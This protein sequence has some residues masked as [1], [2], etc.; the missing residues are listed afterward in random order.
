VSRDGQS[1]HPIAIYA[2]GALD[3]AADGRSEELGFIESALSAPE[4][5]RVVISGRR[6]WKEPCRPQA[7]GLFACQDAGMLSV[8]STARTLP[9]RG[10]L[11][12]AVERDR[13][14]RLVSGVSTR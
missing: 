13:H 8:P 10:Y 14:R 2:S 3:V 11:V 5:C 4:I 12:G 9:R 6:C 1:Q 7:R